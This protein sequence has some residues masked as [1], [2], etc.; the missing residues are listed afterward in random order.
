MSTIHELIPQAMAKVGA[1]AKGRKNQQ[2]GYSFRGID[3][4]YAAFQPVFAE[5][6]IFVVPTVQNITR[7]ERQTKSGG[8]LIYTTLTVKHTFYASDGSSLDAVTV[9]EAMD[10][11]DKA[12]NKAMSAAL[13]YALTELFLIPT[14]EKDRDT[15]EASPEMAAKA[16]QR[17]RACRRFRW[18]GRKSDIASARRRGR[19]VQCIASSAFDEPP[20]F[21]LACLP[22]RKRMS[23]SVPLTRTS[24][25]RR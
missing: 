17:L 24:S 11:G 6:G 10:S 4:A 2:Q 19:H 7:E 25:H 5:L 12:S 16:S 21:F 23:I 8:A 15:E 18:S 22:L 3:D 1:I 13:K 14:Y 9:G 20:D